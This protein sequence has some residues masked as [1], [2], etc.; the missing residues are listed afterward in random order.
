MWLYLPGSRN[1][2][3]SVAA[4]HAACCQRINAVPEMMLCASALLLPD[5]D[6]SCNRRNIRKSPLSQLELYVG[7]RLEIKGIKYM[8]Y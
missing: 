2:R 8:K 7:V 5:D 6:T 3:L 4:A 1:T